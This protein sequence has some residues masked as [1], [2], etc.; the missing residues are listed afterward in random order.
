MWKEAY[1]STRVLNAGREYGDSLSSPHRRTANVI[2]QGLILWQLCK[3]L[4]TRK[5]FCSLRGGSC[6]CVTSPSNG[7]AAR[8]EVGG[9]LTQ[10]PAAARGGRMVRD[11]GMRLRRAAIGL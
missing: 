3:C 5:S 8:V 11:G 6:R 9:R 4:R 10:S 7:V 2:P 1:H